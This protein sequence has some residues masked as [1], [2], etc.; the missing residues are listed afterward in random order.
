MRYVPPFE[1]IKQLLRFGTVRGETVVTLTY[2]EM[3]TLLRTL[4]TAFE[5]DEAFYLSQNPD[6]AQGVKD[7]TIQS[8]R[9]HFIDHGYFEGRQA[10]H[11]DIDEAWY[12]EQNPDIAE[13]VRRGEYESA[14]A[15]FDGSGYREGRLP[16]PLR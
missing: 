11:V 14:Q 12:L 9:G 2:E 1:N 7:G 16:F 5:V 4:L 15:H 3:Q 8:A 13:V 6:V 10:S